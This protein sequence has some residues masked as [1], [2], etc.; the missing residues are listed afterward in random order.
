MDYQ[1]SVSMT[2]KDL[3][4]N[5]ESA[6]DQLQKSN[7]QYNAL[8]LRSTSGVSIQ[9]YDASGSLIQTI[10]GN[11]NNFSLEGVSFI[12]LTGTNATTLYLTYA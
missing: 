2:Y 1:G 3:Y 7:I 12:K 10:S 4:I 9:L 8:Y 11:T 6:R 5:I